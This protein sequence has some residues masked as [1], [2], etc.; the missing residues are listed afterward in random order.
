MILDLAGSGAAAPRRG[1][2]LGCRIALALALALLILVLPAARAKGDRVSWS[3]YGFNVQRT[4]Y[5]RR[6][7]AISTTNVSHL[8]LLWTKDLGGPMVAQPVEAAGVRVGGGAMNLV[9]EGTENGDLYALRSKDG[10]VVWHKYLGSVTNSCLDIP[11]R[12][13]GI[14]DSGAISFSGPGS[15][16]IYIVGGDGAVHALDLA[17]GAERTGWPL[18]VFNPSQETIYSG[19]NLFQ[20]KLYVA[21]A[22]HCDSA[23]YYAGAVEIDVARHSIIHRFYPAGPPSGGI[24]GGGIWGPGGVSIDPASRDIFAAT[25]NAVAK[26]D[27]YRYSD[28]VVRLTLSLRV[29]SWV[30]P[31][32][33]G[34]D[35][36]FGATPIL[37]KPAGCPSQLT[38]AENKNGALYVYPTSDLRS[39]RSQRLQMAGKYEFFSGIPAWDPRTNLLYVGNPADSPTGPF[40]HGMVALKAGPGCK[41]SLAWQRGEGINDESV[42]PPTVANGVVYYG[43]GPGNKELAFDAATGKQLWSSGTTI[44]EALFAAPTVIN[45]KV[46]AAGWYHQLYSFGP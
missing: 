11:D 40:R 4:G 19:L 37:F 44:G 26:Q 2:A 3:T 38:A 9:Y 18:Q 24:S 29:R 20:G 12:V 32:L 34:T 25:G 39:G 8:H 10:G 22:S 41:L 28:A 6:E 46:F 21:T 36:D 33:S 42:S 43:D 45:G 13:Y 17:T 5:N 27:N 30:K 31:K 14:G 7:E 23:P 35:V 16:V 1:A 15:G